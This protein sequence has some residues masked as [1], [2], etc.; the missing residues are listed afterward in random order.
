MAHADDVSG[1]SER[2]RGHGDPDREN[3]SATQ[4]AQGQVLA[5]LLGEPIA[6]AQFLPL[7]VSITASLVR[8]HERGIIH[9]DLKPGHVVLAPEG[10]IR[11]AGFALS[12]RVRQERSPLQPAEL[13]IDSLAYMSPERTGRMNRSTDSRSDLYSL[14]V[15]FYHLLTGVLPFPATD[16]LEL[17]HCHIARSPLPPDVHVPLPSPLVDMIMKLLEK[18]PELRYQTADGLEHDLRRCVTD[19]R[20]HG[21]IRPFTL[22]ARDASDRLIITEKLYGRERSIAI[23]EQAFESVVANRCP[24]LVLVSG[25][26]GVGK[27]KLVHELQRISA[28]HSG[29]YGSGKFDRF[30]RDFPHATLAQSLR[31]LVSQLLAKPETELAKF[32]RAFQEALGPNAQLMIDLVPEMT[33]IVGAQAPVAEIP[34]RDARA[35]FQSVFR[36]FVEVFAQP[37]HPLVLFFDDLQWADEAT[38]DLLEFLVTEANIRSL[39][40]IGAY[41]SDQPRI[42]EKVAEAIP[43]VRRSGARVDEIRLAPLEAADVC[44]L[45]AETL[46]SDPATVAPLA[47]VLW[48]KTAGNPLFVNQ[49]LMSLEQERL[50]TFDQARREWRWDLDDVRAKRHSDNLGDLLVTRLHLLPGETIEALKL[51]ASFGTASGLGLL[52]AVSGIEA[53]ALRTHLGAAEA[54]GIVTQILATYQFT[55]D[56][57]QD[58]AYSLIGNE[59]KTALHHRIG[60]MLHSQCRPEDLDKH[61]FDIVNQLNRGAALLASAEERRELASLNLRAG[62]KAK[63]ATSYPTALNYLM[64]G[65][66]LLPPD[67]LGAGDDLAFSLALHL[68]ECEMLT[69][70]LHAAEG[71][72]RQLAELAQNLIDSAA[73]TWL[74]ASLYVAL[75]ENERALDVCLGFLASVGILW[76]VNPQVADVVAELETLRRNIESRPTELLAAQSVLA[77]PVQRATLDVLTAMLAPA[78]GIDQN[79]FQLAIARMVNISIRHG[80]SDGSCLAYAYLGILLREHFG[81]YAAGVHYGRL[82]L[83][84]V[85]QGLSR[86]EA[87]ALQVYGASCSPWIEHPRCGIPY[88][89][90]SM[91]IAAQVGDTSYMGY[92]RYALI[93]HLLASGAPLEEVQREAEESLDFVRGPQYSHA[94]EGVLPHVWLIRFLRGQPSPLLPS[95]DLA[96]EAR[97]FEEG[98]RID[99]TRGYG[100]CWFW[101]RRM[102]ALVLS[103]D[104]PAAIAAAASASRALEARLR[105]LRPYEEVEFHFFA[106][107]ALAVEIDRVTPELRSDYL[108]RLEQHARHLATLATHNPESFRDRSHL[109]AA[110]IARIRGNSAEAEAHYDNAIC[111]AREGGFV[112]IEALASEVSARHYQAR[113]LRSIGV[114]MLRNAIDCYRRWGALGKLRQLQHTATMVRPETDADAAGHDSAKFHAQVDLDTVARAAQAISGELDLSRLLET[115]L[116]LVIEHAG[117]ERGLVL[118]LHDEVPRIEAEAIADGKSIRVQVRPSAILLKRLPE[119]LLNY[120]IRTRRS[121]LLDDALRSDV[122]GA[123]EYVR[124]SQPKSVLCLPLA[125][126]AKLV[127]VLYLEN[128]LAAYAFTPERSALIELL[129]AQIAVALENARIHANVREHEGRIRSLLESKVIGIE[130]WDVHGAVYDANDAWLEI[131]GYTRAELLAGSIRWTEITPPEYRSLD[132]K[133]CTAGS[134]GVSPPYEKE[135]LRKDGTRVPVLIGGTFLDGSNERGVAFVLNLS[136]H[137]LAE[138]ERTARGIAEAATR[139]KSEFLAHMSHELRTPLNGILGYTAIMARDPQLNTRQADA[140]RV[141]QHSG[142]HLLRLIED[143]LDLAAI[144]AGKLPLDPT[145]V[146]TAEF[147]DFLLDAIRLRCEEK[148]LSLIYQRDPL[149]PPSI[150]IDDRRLRQVLLNLLDNAIKFTDAGQ[151]LLSVEMAQTTRIRFAVRDSGIGMTD[152]QLQRI[153]QPFEQVGE[154]RRR[155]G[156]AGLGLAI[157]RRI[158]RLMG[159]ELVVSSRIGEGSEFSFELDVKLAE[160]SLEAPGRLICGYLGPKKRVLVL[161]DLRDNRRLLQS[162]L[163]SLGFLVDAAASGREGLSMSQTQRPDLVIT[164]L[165]MPDM[166]G[167][168]FIRR[169][170][171]LPALGDVPVI[172]LSARRETHED[173]GHVDARASVFLLKP[174]DLDRLLAAVTSLLRVDW[175]W[176]EVSLESAAT[177]QSR[178][179]S[180]APTQRSEAWIVPPYHE[181]LVLHGFALQGS[182]RDILAWTERIA[183]SDARYREFA[184]TLRGLA[185]QFRSQSILKLVEQHLQLHAWDGT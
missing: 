78:V 64:T 152:Q 76:P 103:A 102:Q 124:L 97:A 71:S 54:A 90:R 178:A 165:V 13:L 134:S 33:S 24:H 89:R 77:D 34:A 176:K 26:P 163:E 83:K 28:G 156:G 136:T 52:T 140:L 92:N 126:Q 2:S 14:G 121:V 5:N 22:G 47:D 21:D 170:R 96:H 6:I 122:F 68:G 62:L 144:E 79:L 17:I 80:N 53:D 41:R 171:E 23:L 160:A 27:S 128:R 162:F 49:F 146:R 127:G 135:Y 174:V 110:E 141:I 32:R 147:V 29:L 10:E 7:A 57:V 18:A 39:M 51:L 15:M 55:H 61:I 40:L 1:S 106:G 108:D 59:A 66:D 99:A 167:H 85:E 183:G 67:A 114:A 151:V 20:L 8:V 74:R 60:R 45:V 84:L 132:E 70:R 12:S 118:M 56:R 168:A 182:M 149:L 86:F 159:G 44:Q 73:V 42:A 175:I 35:R 155:H 91:S 138:N 185:K 129:A 115:L 180:D 104:F 153:F 123:D 19:W 137:K 169:L 38:M 43:R 177:Q 100:A 46:R 130:F 166:D 120:V 48:V 158:V 142:Q 139:A 119:S 109:L 82:S 3:H 93:A 125:K 16:P 11:L 112:H 65:R 37:E 161:D 116:T 145:P 25:D 30:T 31:S 113:G 4:E 154:R 94:I 105:I 179:P 148:G 87:R 101:I 133:F 172:M 184:N 107:L 9:R 81:E 95:Q 50:L 72:L 157:S 58:A 75:G 143:S 69:G 173:L 181:L 63:A 131:V 98:G 111:A 36:A 164:D 88:I 150:E 117:A